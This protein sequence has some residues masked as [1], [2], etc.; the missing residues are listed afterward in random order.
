MLLHQQHGGIELVMVEAIGGALRHDL[1][2]PGGDGVEPIGDDAAGDVA[3]GDDPDQPAMIR[4]G[5]IADAL[6]VHLL[7]DFSH[8]LIR[9]R[10]LD[11][12]R[13]D[14]FHFHLRLHCGQ[15]NAASLIAERAALTCI[16]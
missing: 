14:L 12:P 10:G 4:H 1:A 13:H 9:M 11:V 7:R 6:A 2:Q 15:A 3:I 5:K 16:K 8:R